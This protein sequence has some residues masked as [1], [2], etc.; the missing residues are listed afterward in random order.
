MCG[1]RPS[2][3]TNSNIPSTFVVAFGRQ[4]L[5]QCAYLHA[6]VSG[7]CVE[8]GTDGHLVASDP[9]CSERDPENFDADLDEEGTEQET[10]PTRKW[11]N[12]YAGVR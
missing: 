8:A 12:G 4:Q 2:A 1:L 11:P 3:V 7:C 6:V 10:S 5:K 9:S